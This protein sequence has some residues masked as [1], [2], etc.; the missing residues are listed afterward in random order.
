MTV[1]PTNLAA[2][3]PR[4][5]KPSSPID[6]TGDVVEV[7]YDGQASPGFLVA[8]AGVRRVPTSRRLTRS[9]R[10]RS[11][12]I[13]GLDLDDAASRRV[14]A[15]DRRA[16]DREVVDGARDRADVAPAIDDGN[17]ESAR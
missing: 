6:A 14:G 10:Q 12:S 2:E 7:L 8:T 4:D 13:V 17:G 1:S 3:D 15:T 16:E 9:G 11:G 5:G